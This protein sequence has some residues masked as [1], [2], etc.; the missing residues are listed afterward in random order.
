VNASPLLFFEAEID[1]VLDQYVSSTSAALS[2]GLG[3]FAAMGL[4]IYFMVLGLAV[5]RGDVEQPM[6]KILKDSFAM[7]IIASIAVVVGVYQQ[8]IIGVVHG[9]LALL[10]SKM[11]GGSAKT[12]IES[13]S[14]VFET[15]DVAVLVNGEAISL[16]RALWVIALKKANYFGIPDPSYFF[17]ALCVALAT[18]VVSALCILPMLLS[19]VAIALCLAIGPLFI[20][21]GMF[22]QTKNYFTAWLSNLVGNIFTGMLIAAVCSL[23][24]TVFI[25]T[26]TKAL[27]GAGSETFSP[28]AMG[29]AML[30]LGVV[31]GF[32]ALNVSQLG[33]QLAGGGAA[34]DSKGLAGTLVNYFL[35]KPKDDKDKTPD[36]PINSAE[37]TPAS[38]AAGQRARQIISSIGKRGG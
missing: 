35:S 9:V 38:Y 14:L 13:A 29:F 17:A 24:T 16:D 30:I 3:V 12:V 5:A 19:K 11:S 8:Q 1:M 28:L 27:D 26:L 33:A 23:M 21:L 36:A 4:T 22:P 7:V 32:T 34:L 37:A 25:S 15:T 10:V 18:V 20:M 2:A 6:S 31:L